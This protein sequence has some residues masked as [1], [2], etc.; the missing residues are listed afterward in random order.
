MSRQLND[1]IDS[2]LSYQANTEPPDMYKIWTAIS[3][4]AACLKR[5][6]HL[7]WGSLI[8]YPNMYVVLVG[9]S[10]RCRKGTAMGPGYELLLEMNVKLAAEATTREG[11]IRELRTSSDT[12]IDIQ[13]GRQILHSSL[14]IYSQELTVFLGYNNSQLM[15][16]LTDWYDC[17]PRW[18][19]GP[20]GA[21]LRDYIVNVWVNL[22]GAT[23]PSLIQTALPQ[24]AVGGGLTSRII[25]VY[26]SNKGQVCPEPFY[27]E[28]QLT[29]RSALLHDLEM[30][31]SMSGRFT[32]NTAFR[33]N[34]VDWYIKQ[35]SNPP[36]KDERLAGYCERRATHLM[37]LSTI[38]CASRTQDMNLTA[39]DFHRAKIILEETEKKMPLVFGGVG[40]SQI[41]P[42]INKII[43]LLMQE[44]EVPYEILV[45]LFSH[46]VD[47][48]GLNKAID[49]IEAMKVGTI[50]NRSGKKFLILRE[51]N[52]K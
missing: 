44:G 28:E 52:T 18:N 41:A 48:H 15:S 32:Y 11:L 42:V 35:D 1:W 33:D 10:G 38:L 39:I 30:I 8:F 6:C 43:M 14:T 7:E 51:E 40:K 5:K 3:V 45:K 2:Y 21:E 25:F 26:E 22:F 16:D 4:V 50:I 34:Y 23:T 9:P 36:F 17:R 47:V 12:H 19:Y 20:K 46:D 49:T 24:D 37:K 31:H 13:T 27:T 29:I